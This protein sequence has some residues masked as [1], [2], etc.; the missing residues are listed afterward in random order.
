MSEFSPL[1]EAVDTVA[2]RAPSPDFGEL[3][4]R[5]AHR[6]RRRTFT[7]ALTVVVIAGT[8]LASTV[9]SANLRAVPAAPAA[10][11]EWPKP[12]P[13]FTPSA[14]H[15]PTP[16]M[17]ARL[18]LRG[19]GIGPFTFGAN[20]VD[21]A[22]VLNDRLGDPDTTEQGILCPLGRTGDPWAEYV[23]YGAQVST[24]AGAGPFSVY[25]T[26]KD[27]SEKSPRYLTAWGFNLEEKLPAALAMQDDVPLNLSFDQ[28]KAKYPAGKPSLPGDD[29]YEFIL[30]NKLRFINNAGVSRPG[31]VVAGQKVPC[32]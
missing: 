26:A 4:R 23:T 32:E 18:T 14:T 13:P 5:A 6:G 22:A 27:Q 28:L 3:K 11:P 7:A 8:L 17:E 30:P 1:R 2:S 20:Q 15:T 12:L 9:V 19:D 16:A 21:V 24:S 10:N 25:Y 31:L 29:F